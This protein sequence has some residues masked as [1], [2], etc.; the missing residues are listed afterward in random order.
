M[1][2]GSYTAL[3]TP[4]KAE[5]VYEV[6][7][8]SLE[9]LIERQIAGKI[10]GIVP[11]GTTGESPTLTNEEHDKVI[12]YSIRA[13]NKRAK[14]M[15]GTGSN[16]TKEAIERTLHAQ[17]AGADAALI[18]T[19][20]YNKPSQ[21]GIFQHFKAIH[22]ITKIPIVIYNI[23]SRSVVDIKDE[24]IARIAQ[25]E[26]IVGLKDATGN[27]DRPTSLAKLLP[28]GKEFFQLS[29]DDET[30]VKF[31]QLGG[32]GCIS[33]TSNIDP[34]TCAK[35]QNACLTG[36]FALAEKLD[37]KTAELHKILFIETS[38]APVKYI[39]GLMGLCSD[40]LRLPLVLPL[41]EN[42]AKLKAAYERWKNS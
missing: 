19:P 16:S 14:I 8:K 24:T 2:K 15:A 9:K 21:E 18:M 26:R 30:A 35:V 34:E 20:Y 40:K 10:H 7:Y 32:V 29:G 4:F 13:V 23:P 36:D 6:D 11:C 33:V 42:K 39:S 27:L 25:L 5:N 22:D 37:Q 31:N 1:L 38:P 28:K 41:D 17:H 12:E 3:I